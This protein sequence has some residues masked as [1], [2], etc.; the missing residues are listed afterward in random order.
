MAKDGAVMAAHIPFALI[1]VLCCSWNLFHT[2]GH[3]S[4]YRKAHKVI[5]WTAMGFGFVSVVTGYAFIMGGTSTAHIGT[6]I[7]MMTIGFLQLS[8]QMLGLWYVKGYKWVHMHQ[9]MMTYLFCARYASATRA[10]QASVAS[11]RP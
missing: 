3:G 7:L 9:S 10:A 8:L 4:F 2:P 6:K 5:G 11:L 1:F